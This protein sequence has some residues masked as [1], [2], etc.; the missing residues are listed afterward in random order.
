MALVRQSSSSGTS[1]SSNNPGRLLE[2]AIAGFENALSEDQ[3]IELRQTK[4]VPDAD[5]VMTFT[6]HLDAANRSRRGRSIASRLHTVL[7]CVRDFTAI[8]DTLVSSN[9]D[10]AA[11]VWGSVK[12]TMLVG[13]RTRCI[14]ETRC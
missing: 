9:P 12:L 1:A 6:A 4:A 8:V 10:V 13:N 7:Q 14:L 3:L 11:V 2:E 5:A